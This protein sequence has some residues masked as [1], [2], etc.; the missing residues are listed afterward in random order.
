MVKSMWAYFGLVDA[1]LETLHELRRRRP[2]LRRRSGW[3]RRWPRWGSSRRS[4]SRRSRWSRDPGPRPESES[5]DPHAVSVTASAS[6]ARAPVRRARVGRTACMG[7]PDGDEQGTLKP[8][9]RR[10]ADRPERWQSPPPGRAARGRRACRRAGDD[11]ADEHH[12]QQ[13][14][15]QVERTAAAVEAHDAQAGGELAERTAGQRGQHGRLQD[16]HAHRVEARRPALAPP[17]RPHDRHDHQRGD[18]PVHEQRE[19]AARPGRRTQLWF[20]DWLTPSA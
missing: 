1:R 5:S 16:E 11:Q 17:G 4:R 2:A 6:A 7:T 20:G 13:R 18:R 9:C 8:T 10:H 19:D 3:A 14:L 12:P 15:Q